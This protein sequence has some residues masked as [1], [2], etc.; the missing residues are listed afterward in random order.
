MSQANLGYSS[1]S[2][3]FHALLPWFLGLLAAC[4]SNAAELPAAG[5][6]GGAASPSAGQPAGGA[7]SG[8]GG[9]SSASGG[10]G[11]GNPTMAGA[12]GVPAQGG[13]GGMGGMGGMGGSGGAV[14]GSGGSGGGTGGGS[15]ATG[16]GA[17]AKNVCPANGS[18]SDPSKGIGTVTEVK[19]PDGSFFAFI[20]GAMW[21]ASTKT[22]FFSDNA[23]S[24][25]RLWM[26]DPATSMVTKALEGSGSNGLAVDPDD[27]LVVADQAD[28]AL[29]RFDPAAKAK[30]GSN[31]AAA[32]YKPN[33]VV[34]RSDGSIYVSDP[35]TGVWFVPP[36]GT[37]A[38]LATK[39]VNRPNGIVLSLD[40]NTLIVG[41]V[42]N[43]SITKFPLS[44]DGKVMDTPTAFGKSMGQTADGMCMD[45]AG[46]LY[47]STQT[48]VDII[49]PSGKLLGTV[50][51]GESS[52]CTFGGDDRKTL[53]VTSRAVLKVVK[54]AN[55]GLPD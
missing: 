42:G 19:A 52:N 14:G 5:G 37:A 34:V 6:S 7:S 30:L 10:A 8:G 47:V 38:Q 54:L 28:K 16:K 33:D 50:P 22:L 49:D 35:D 40:E 3:K 13:V 4:S 31:F 2:S 9:A 32:S 45:C 20:E 25:E 12:G 36:G 29:Y 1:V 44:A 21:V 39:S 26:L 18:Y 53:F 27:K 46:N 41:D 17:S 23:G 51:T 11:G 15:A 43:Q 24:P 48:G 55:P